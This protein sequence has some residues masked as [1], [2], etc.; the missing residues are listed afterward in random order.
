MGII[1]NR[2]Y[3]REV[4]QEVIGQCSG[5]GISAPRAEGLSVYQWP[6][7]GKNKQGG[8]GNVFVN[9]PLKFLGFS[10]KFWQNGRS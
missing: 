1:C 4:Q 9:M 3:F 5:K 6:V 8:G 10:W 2:F 7:P